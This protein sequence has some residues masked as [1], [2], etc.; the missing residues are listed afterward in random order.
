MSIRKFKSLFFTNL[1]RVKALL[2]IAG[3]VWLSYLLIGTN[4]LPDASNAGFD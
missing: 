2:G 3:V 1:S 4:V